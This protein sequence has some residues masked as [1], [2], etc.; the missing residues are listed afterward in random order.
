MFCSYIFIYVCGYRKKRLYLVETL[1]NIPVLRMKNGHTT[2]LLILYPSA[3]KKRKEIIA[4]LLK[5]IE[6]KQRH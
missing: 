1:S 5:L 2:V 4:Y 3:Y 6:R